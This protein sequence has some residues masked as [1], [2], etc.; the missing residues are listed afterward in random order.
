MRGDRA[1]LLLLVAAIGYH[2]MRWGLGQV[3]ELVS[4][5]VPCVHFY[6]MNDARPAV[7]IIK[8]LG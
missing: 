8:D 5:G 2:G 1:G 6:V 4:R 3:T 7:Q